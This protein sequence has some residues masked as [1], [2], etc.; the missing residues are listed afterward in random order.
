MFHLGSSY[1]FHP[2]RLQCSYVWHLTL[3]GVP[4]QRSIVV[5]HVATSN[6]I[7]IVYILTYVFMY[8]S[9]QR[10]VIVGGRVKTSTVSLRNQESSSLAALFCYVIQ[11][12][13]YSHVYPIKSQEKNRLEKGHLQRPFILKHQLLSHFFLSY[14]FYCKYFY[15]IFLVNEKIKEKG[16]RKGDEKNL[17]YK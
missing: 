15:Y 4:T 7:I 9:W 12:C 6:I 11:A 5:V 14:I 2:A 1:W 17:T 3:E 8:S 13:H 16:W 10:H